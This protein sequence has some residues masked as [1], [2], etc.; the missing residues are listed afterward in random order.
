MALVWLA[1][2]GSLAG[3]RRGL[4]A[5]A[6]GLAEAGAVA[7]TVDHFV[8]QMAPVDLHSSSLIPLILLELPAGAVPVTGS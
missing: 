1:R 5:P 7:G 2:A 8:D 4:Y 3:H 6:R